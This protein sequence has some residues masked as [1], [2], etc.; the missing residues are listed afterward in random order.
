[1]KSYQIALG[2]VSALLVAM[3]TAVCAEPVDELVV[4]ALQDNP[5]IK[6][7]T[8]RWEMFTQKARQAG[9]FDDPMVMFGIKNGLIRDPSR[10]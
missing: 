3:A 10:F 2:L 1:M 8:A 7:S 4:L 9:A 5:E 6:A